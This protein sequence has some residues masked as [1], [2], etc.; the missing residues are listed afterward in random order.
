VVTWLHISLQ[1]H[2]SCR[3]HCWRGVLNRHPAQHPLLANQS[4][5]AGSPDGGFSMNKRRG[6]RGGEGDGVQRRYIQVRRRRCCRTNV[7]SG[8]RRVRCIARRRQRRFHR[9][10]VHR[11]AVV[12]PA[13][14]WSYLDGLNADLRVS[15]FL[16]IGTPAPFD[17]SAVFRNIFEVLVVW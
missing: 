12:Q 11:V 9:F 15:C 8:R 6:V 3:D 2:I 5:T 1:S 10:H 13:S 14:R 16:I 4:A 17:I 7:A